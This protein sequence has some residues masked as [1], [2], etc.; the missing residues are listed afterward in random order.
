[1][2]IKLAVLF[3]LIAVASAWADKVL[4]IKTLVANDVQRIT[5]ERS[6]VLCTIQYQYQLKDSTGQA[7]GHHKVRTIFSGAS[8]PAAIENYIVNQILPH[9]NSAEGM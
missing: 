5:I 6:A 3:V 8:C 9:A 1:M 4:T 2:G 7:V